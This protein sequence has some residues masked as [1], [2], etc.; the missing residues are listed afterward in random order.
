METS[1]TPLRYPGGKQQMSKYIKQLVE[2]NG[3]SDGLYVEPYAGGA[4]VAFDLLFSYYVSYIWL[5][6]LDPNIY[7]FWYCVLNQTEELVSRIMNTTVSI[8]SWEDQKR[9]FNSAD[10]STPL[11]DRGFATFF[12]NRCNRSGILSAGPIG[13]KRQTGAW[14]IDARFNKG[15]LVARIRKIA[16]YK[17]RIRLSNKD[18]LEFLKDIEPVLK[19]A[20]PSFVYLDPPYYEKGQELYLNA[21][22]PA[23]HKVLSEFLLAEYKDYNWIVSYDA[24]P[25]IIALYGKVCRST[26]QILN[27]S[28]TTHK[29]GRELMYYSASIKIPETATVMPAIQDKSFSSDCF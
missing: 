9:I 7:A 2:V 5:N 19:G 16:R 6:D 22:A 1:K 11:V 8:E 27:Y 20:L 3:I 12:L 28:V 23:D 18:C 14:K 25:E 24:C 4:G 21:Y 10:A 13:G 17:T 26:E 29:K 15:D